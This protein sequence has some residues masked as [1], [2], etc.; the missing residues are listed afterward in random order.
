METSNDPLRAYLER[1]LHEHAPPRLLLMGQDPTRRDALQALAS[2]DGA[3]CTASSVADMSDTDLTAARFDLAIV[4]PAMLSELNKREGRQLISRLRDQ[5]A[6]TVLVCV[7]TRAQ[8]AERWT[9]SDFIALG[10]RR[11]PDSRS[12]GPAV[13]VYRYDIRD[14][15]TTPD[16][17]NSRYW[18]NPERWDR[19]RW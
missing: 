7:D 10:F 11:S 19:E 17:L 18:A 3:V 9:I 8:A 12:I 5:L 14:Y 13:A 1:C 2:R 6:G 4:L 15:K 16:W